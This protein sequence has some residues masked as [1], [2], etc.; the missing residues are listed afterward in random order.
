VRSFCEVFLSVDP[1][2]DQFPA[3]SPYNYT[4]NNPINMIDPDGRAPEH[5]VDGQG[6]IAY[7]KQGG[8]TKYATKDIRRVGNA[9]MS[10]RTGKIQWNNM[11]D[12]DHN[13]S[14]SISNEKKVTTLSNGSVKYELGKTFQKRI[15]GAESFSLKSVKSS[16][17]VIYEGSLNFYIN[18]TTNT[19]S[20]L[21][22]SYSV[23]TNSMDQAIGAVGA[24]ESFHATDM[25]NH[26]QSVENK[27]LGANHDIEAGPHKVE[28]QMLNE[29]GMNNIKPLPSLPIKLKY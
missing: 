26:K 27:Y 8:Y 23:N 19:S 21:R 7:T 9:M 16:D 3:Y 25:Q 29:A 20:K 4:M 11:V 17:I 6:N 24:H 2:A 22:Q 14:I 15:I 5:I 13:I 10:T 1:L 18:N 12:A 28:Y